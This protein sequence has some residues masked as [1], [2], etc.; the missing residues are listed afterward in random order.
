MVISPVLGDFVIKWMSIL[1]I[2]S[3]TKQLICREMCQTCVGSEYSCYHVQNPTG[4][5][6]FKLYDW[7]PGDFPRQLRQQVD[8]AHIRSFGTA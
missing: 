7:N 2:L 1:V 6:S 8:A 5:I 4:R 3:T